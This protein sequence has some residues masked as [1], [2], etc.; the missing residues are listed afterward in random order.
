[1]MTK[2]MEA[3][4]EVVKIQENSIASARLDAVRELIR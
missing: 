1:M 3:R 4:E 2:S